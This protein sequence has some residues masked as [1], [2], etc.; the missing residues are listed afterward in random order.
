MTDT[1]GTSLDKS[2]D[3]RTAPREKQDMADVIARMKPALEKSLGRADVAEMLMRHYLTAYRL[4]PKLQTC[5]TDSVLAALLLS[6]Q[7]RLEP[8]PLG[9]VYLVPYKSE[10]VWMLGY[11]GIV[12]L[13]RRSDRLGA[14]RARVVWDCDDYEYAEKDGE[15]HYSLRPGSVADQNERRLVLVTWQEKAGGKWFKRA[16]E[17]APSRIARALN[18][19]PAAKANSGPW[20]GSESDVTAMWC[21]TGI[22]AVRPWLPLTSDAG[23]A[24]ASDD[25]MLTGVETDREGAAQPV[26]VASDE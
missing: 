25:A 11:T 13:G 18:A 8:G 14:L 5:S 4:N 24:I 26:L 16:V 17:V 19:S 3:K 20:C 12:E 10:V 7:V 21:K 2:E 9:H 15:E 23:Y 6:A 22:R 1:L